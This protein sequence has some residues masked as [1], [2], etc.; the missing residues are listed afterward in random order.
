MSVFLDATSEDQ[1]LHAN[2]ATMLAPSLPFSV[3]LWVYFE[4]IPDEGTQIIWWYGDKD[5]ASDYVRLELDNANQKFQITAGSAYAS[6]SAVVCPNAIS[7]G[8]WHLVTFVAEHDSDTDLLTHRLFVDDQNAA[9]QSAT[10]TDPSASAWDRFTLGRRGTS[11]GFG[12]RLLATCLVEQ[13]AIWSAALDR[14][15]HHEMWSS[16]DEDFDGLPRSPNAIGNDPDLAWWVLA[17][18][19]R[20]AL[21]VDHSQVGVDAGDLWNQTHD[22]VAN[23]QIDSGTPTWSVE[24]PAVF[25]PPPPAVTVPKRPSKRAA[26]RMT[27]KFYFFFQKP[28]LFPDVVTK[29][30]EGGHPAWDD[31]RCVVGARVQPDDLNTNALRP[32][33]YADDYLFQSYVTQVARRIADWSEYQGFADGTG[34]EAGAAEGNVLI[35][36]LG[37]QNDKGSVGLSKSQSTPVANQP[38]SGTGIPLEQHPLDGLQPDNYSSPSNPGTLLHISMYRD[39]GQQLMGEYGAQLW[40]ALKNELDRRSLCYP[41]RFHF[42]YEGSLPGGAYFKGSEGDPPNQLTWDCAWQYHQFTDGDGG[43][44]DEPRWDSEPVLGSDTLADIY[45]F[46]GSPPDF[47]PDKGFLASENDEFRQWFFG[48][49]NA[50]IMEALDIA[51]F[52]QATTT[53]PDAL[54]ANQHCFVADDPRFMYPEPTADRIYNTIVSTLPQDFTSP[55]LYPPSNFDSFR[56]DTSRDW[57]ATN[58]SI[59]HSVVRARIDARVNSSIK[60]PLSPTF[61]GVGFQRRDQTNGDLLFELSFEDMVQTLF[62]AWRRGMN[63]ARLWVYSGGT[64][65]DEG[66]EEDL[67][68]PSDVADFDE[69]YRACRWVSDTIETMTY[70]SRDRTCRHCRVW[71]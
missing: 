3:S 5:S 19:Y 46:D 9:S 6:I 66:T 53:F 49:R 65:V 48:Y 32:P 61:A 22:D 27:P 63:E 55:V 68:F 64:D 59:F 17:G 57:G 2:H 14:E 56:E 62:Y 16:T 13:A 10:V 25:F 41:A 26:S 50:L 33:E 39:K 31:P 40:A 29:Y 36:R 8:S 34:S 15:D 21:E 12:G 43:S 30:G 35:Q 42:D 69:T 70:Y 52:N 60:Y 47:D 24:T 67:D 37:H 58:R 18:H 44:N 23:M 1:S 54:W 7:P 51:L 4:S 28:E 45:T 20:H 38:G 71:R 11:L